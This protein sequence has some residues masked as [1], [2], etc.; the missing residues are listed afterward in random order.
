MIYIHESL[1]VTKTKLLS[2]RIA[3]KTRK[4][5]VDRKRGNLNYSKKNRERERCGWMSK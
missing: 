4:K 1:N 5:F 3:R 2:N